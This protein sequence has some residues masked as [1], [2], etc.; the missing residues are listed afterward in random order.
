M[1]Q[2]YD[3]QRVVSANSM[4]DEDVFD[5]DSSCQLHAVSKCICL[6]SGFIFF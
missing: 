6:M 1:P 3:L 5:I 2:C 4:G